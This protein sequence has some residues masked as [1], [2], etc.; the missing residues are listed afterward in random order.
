M[1]FSAQ[2]GAAAHKPKKLLAGFSTYPAAAA[3]KNLEGLVLVTFRINDTGTAE[4]VEMN[5]SDS[6]FS[7]DVLAKL[8]KIQLSPKDDR[9]GKSFSYRIRYRSEK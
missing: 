1:M 6:T 3:Q 7:S 8:N 2:A 5:A 9:I 4:I